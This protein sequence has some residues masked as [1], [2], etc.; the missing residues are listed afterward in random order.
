MGANFRLRAGFRKSQSTKIAPSPPFAMISARAIAI[1][2]L[3]SFGKADVIA[4][5]LVGLPSLFRSA[6]TL[7]AQDQ[8]REARER[9]FNR[10]P[11]DTVIAHNRSRT[12]RPVGF[13]HIRHSLDPALNSRNNRQAIRLKNALDLTARPE[14]A[15]GQIAQKS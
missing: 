10:G 7:I 2:D 11:I 6:A 13:P 8:F 4:I 14:H 3:P 1:V 9:A 12:E 5:T 15:V